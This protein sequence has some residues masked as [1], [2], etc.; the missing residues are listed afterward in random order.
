MAGTS[1][2]VTVSVTV[3]TD[4]AN[5]FRIFTEETNLWWRSGPRFRIAGKQ[6][7]VVRFEPQLGGRFLEEVR[8]PS[9]PKLFTIGTITAWDPPDRFEFEWRGVNFAPGESTQVQVTFEAAGSKT[10]VTVRHSGW[11]TLRPDHPV[12]HGQQ[13]SDFIRRTGLWWGDLMTS[14]REL[15]A[16][17]D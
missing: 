16:G 11:S 14:L 7:G 5:A 1:D 8:A 3:A 10:L 17:G 6:T 9:G 13:G 15:V 12:R 2:V 4:P